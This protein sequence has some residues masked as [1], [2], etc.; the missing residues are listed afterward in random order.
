MKF[1]IH[2]LTQADIPS[3]LLLRHQ[4]FQETPWLKFEPNE[5]GYSRELESRICRN[6]LASQN[7]MISVARSDD[8]F[9]GFVL[10]Q[11]GISSKT[12]H[13]VCIAIAVLEG[14][15]GKGVGAG[16]MDHLHSWAKTTDIHR[17]EL[18]VANP[19]KVA[20]KFFKKYEFVEEGIKHH[21]LLHQGAYID[22]TYMFK[23]L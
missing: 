14:Y 22:Q 17:M 9:V 13:S 15:K 19:N 6:F 4:L 11:E 2:G 21:A 3:L 23:L 7:S 1:T 10:A 12:K 5:E 18:V 16:L 8:N 20:Q